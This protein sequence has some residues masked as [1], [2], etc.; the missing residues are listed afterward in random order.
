VEFGGVNFGLSK[1]I[2][3]MPLPELKERS[4]GWFRRGPNGRCV[5]RRIRTLDRKI[6]FRYQ[7]PNETASP[8]GVRPEYHPALNA[9]ARRGPSLGAASSRRA[10]VVSS[11]TFVNATLI[12]DRS[13]RATFRQYAAACRSAVAASFDMRNLRRL[14]MLA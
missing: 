1:P 12:S 4:T 8:E 14:L 3:A 2:V 11:L 7:S 9:L 6:L 13:E 10:A 5:R